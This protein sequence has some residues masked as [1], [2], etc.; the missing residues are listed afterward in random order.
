MDVHGAVSTA[1]IYLSNLYKDENLTNIG[2]EEVEFD[3]ND[4]EW[5]VTIGFSRPWDTPNNALGVIMA[6][7]ASAQRAYKL[8]TVN[9][10]TGKATSIKNRNLP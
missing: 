1:K 4:N 9:D 10:S 7:R 3:D 2:L 6:P 8:V 5:R